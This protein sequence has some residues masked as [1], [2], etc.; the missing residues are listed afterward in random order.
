MYIMNI[1]LLLI[2]LG[3]L[4]VALGGFH[5]MKQPL[6]KNALNKANS[7]MNQALNRMNK[8]NS[9]MNNKKGN[10]SGNVLQEFQGLPYPQISRD[11]QRLSTGDTPRPMNSYYESS[12]PQSFRQV[13]GKDTPD[14]MVQNRIYIPDY[15]RKDTMSPNNIGTTEY[16]T[17]YM[18]GN[19]A[20]WSDTSFSE[21][22]SFYNPNNLN[23]SNSIVW[24]NK[25]TRSY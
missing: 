8:A 20:P 5:P 6:L 24:T 25:I 7:S 4:C 16:G 9:S 11:I 14:T 19:N 22:P 23:G 3:I 10:N 15:Y 2:L 12:A 1:I 13:R 21:H 18:D 17:P